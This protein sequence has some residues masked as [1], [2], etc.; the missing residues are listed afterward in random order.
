MKITTMTKNRQIKAANE[1]YTIISIGLEL[2]VKQENVG[3]W[4]NGTIID[5]DGTDPTDRSYKIRLTSTKGLTNR[6]R[7]YVQMTPVAAK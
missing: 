3:P 7:R 1:D 2:A 4:T 5:K 6:N